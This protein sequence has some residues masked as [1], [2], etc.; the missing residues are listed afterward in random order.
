MELP[1]TSFELTSI[2]AATS[3]HARQDSHCQLNTVY[4]PFTADIKSSMIKWTTDIVAVITFLNTALSITD[5]LYS[6]HEADRVI[7]N[8]KTEPYQL[9]TLSNATNIDRFATAALNRAVSDLKVI[10]GKLLAGLRLSVPSEE[11]PWMANHCI[12]FCKQHVLAMRQVELA[13]S[14]LGFLES[15]PSIHLRT[16]GEHCVS[17]LAN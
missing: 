11:P 3:L 9:E 12:L 6:N 14:F 4:D 17:R 8:A 10:Y 7:L 5:L 1:T 15:V 2:A 13:Q 16:E